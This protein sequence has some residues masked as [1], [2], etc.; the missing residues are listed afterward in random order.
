MNGKVP[1]DISSLRPGERVRALPRDI[2]QQ[3]S[4][5]V[6]Q[7]IKGLL[8]PGEPAAPRGDAAVLFDG[9]SWLSTVRHVLYLVHDVHQGLEE[10]NQ[11]HPGVR[12]DVDIKQ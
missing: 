11:R 9:R 12:S 10:K 8:C 2:E 3:V 1:S 7:S 6:I 5:D 4:H